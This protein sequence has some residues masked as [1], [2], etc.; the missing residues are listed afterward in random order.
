MGEMKVDSC[1]VIMLIKVMKM[2]YRKHAL[3]DKS[4]GWDELTNA[5]CDA[6]AQVMGDAAFCDWLDKEKGE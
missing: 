6:L 5:M 2:C 1:E 4:I 3:L